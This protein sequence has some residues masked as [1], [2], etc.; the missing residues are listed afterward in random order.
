M[1]IHA[2][3]ETRELLAS[4]SKVLKQRERNQRALEHTLAG[5]V[6]GPIGVMEVLG[7]A[8]G[9]TIY[10]LPFWPEFVSLRCLLPRLATR[11]FFGRIRGPRGLGEIPG[12]LAVRGRPGGDIQRKRNQSGDG[13]VEICFELYIK[14]YEIYLQLNT[15][16]CKYLL[17]GFKALLPRTPERKA[18]LPHGARK[19]IAL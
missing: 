4:T 18:T 12:A 16:Y 6:S 2:C 19:Y 9:S 3:P 5:D 17:E 11:Q 13:I 14:H 1:M 10:D 7:L 15:K 8:P